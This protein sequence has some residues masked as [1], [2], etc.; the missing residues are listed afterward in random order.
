MKELKS[1]RTGQINI[2]SDEEYKEMIHKGVIK[3]NNFLVTDIRVKNIIP[4]LK[5][6]PREIQNKKS[7]I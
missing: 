2:V 6:V 5:E 3:M 1:K 7:K 4:S